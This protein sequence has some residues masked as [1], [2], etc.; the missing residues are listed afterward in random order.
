MGWVTRTIERRYLFNFSNLCRRVNHTRKVPI[1]PPL[2]TSGVRDPSQKTSYQSAYRKRLIS[3]LLSM[4]QQRQMPLV[5][6]AGLPAALPAAQ[7]APSSKGFATC[8]EATGQIVEVSAKRR[9]ADTPAVLLGLVLVHAGLLRLGRT[10]RT[11]AGAGGRAE[12]SLELLV[13]TPLQGLGVLEPRD[14]LHLLLFHLGDEGFRPRPQHL[15]LRHAPLV[16][17][18]VLREPGLFFLFETSLGFFLLLFDVLCALLVHGLLIR[19]T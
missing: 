12:R 4:L 14:E 17:L 7:A 11:R 16:V 18:L 3:F 19:D 6:T 15:L 8:Q 10:R 5:R 13:G 2:K 9:T 1:T